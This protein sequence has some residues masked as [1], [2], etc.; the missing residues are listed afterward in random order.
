[1]PSAHIATAGSSLPDVPTFLS[2]LAS[3]L[4]GRSLTD[5]PHVTFP[6]GTFILVALPVNVAPRPAQ[7]QVATNPDQPGTGN[8]RSR[9][10]RSHTKTQSPGPSETSTKMDGIVHHNSSHQSRHRQDE[11]K[12]Y[13]MICDV[14]NEYADLNLDQR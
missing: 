9:N 2:D 14:I 4:Q 12:A 1:M 3:A 13:S 5:L 6:T 11:G 7:Q 8:G 10:P